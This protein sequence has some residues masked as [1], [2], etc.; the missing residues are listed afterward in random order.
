MAKARSKSRS[1]ITGPVRDLS[2]YVP[3][4]DHLQLTGSA[5]IFDKRDGSLGVRRPAVG[6]YRVGP[7]LRGGRPTD[8]DPKLLSLP[9]IPEIG[10]HFLLGR[11]RGHHQRRK[12]Y[13]RRTDLLRLVDD[14]HRS[15]VHPQ[16]DDRETGQFQQQGH[17]VLAQFV[18]VALDGCDHDR[19]FGRRFGGIEVG[20]H[21]FDAL[22]SQLTRHQQLRHSV[23]VGCQLVATAADAGHDAPIDDLQRILAPV[24]S[25]ADQTDGTFVQPVQGFS[26]LLRTMSSSRPRPRC[27]SKNRYKTLG[28]V[29][30]SSRRPFAPRAT[31]RATSPSGSSRS[32]KV[33]AP[34]G[35][36]ADAG[37]L[38]SLVQSMDAEG[39]LLYHALP[40]STGPIRW[41]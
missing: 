41:K 38:P 20:S 30:C 5:Q 29:P 36:R 34:A 19:G 26:D 8:D 23:F 1:F 4:P 37:R 16:I 40:C 25:L 31:S 3:G 24:E 14:G 18:D 12:R 6:A 15:H 11:H 2:K 17:E 13:H 9:R 21:H 28:L 32:P 35:Q 10:D 33:R 7:G 39:A 27:S 22:L